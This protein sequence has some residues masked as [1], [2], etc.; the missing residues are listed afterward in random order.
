MTYDNN[1]GRFIEIL[2]VVAD[3][4]TRLDNLCLCIISGRSPCSPQTGVLDHFVFTQKLTSILV[5]MVMK[6]Q[7]SRK[8]QYYGSCGFLEDVM[9]GKTRRVHLNGGLNTSA[10]RVRW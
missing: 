7:E 4:V 1:Y 9:W 3:Y 10:P 5:I 8:A 6:L 2:P